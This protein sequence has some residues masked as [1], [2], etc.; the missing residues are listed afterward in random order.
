MR[1]II[2]CGI[3]IT[4]LLILIIPNT[5]QQF[6]SSHNYSPKNCDECHGV[7][8][9]NGIMDN[10]SCQTCHAQSHVSSPS[11]INCHSNTT[12]SSANEAHSPLITHA[13]SSSL[14]RDD[15]EACY[16]CHNNL[17]IDYCYDRPEY[18][19]F[20]ITNNSGNWDINNLNEG[21]IVSDTIVIEKENKSH[22]WTSGGI[23][24]ECHMDVSKNVSLHYPSSTSHSNCN[25]C[26]G[27]SASEH[28]ATV[29]ECSDPGCHVNHVGNLIAEIGNQPEEYRGNMCLGC[30][31]EGHSVVNVANTTTMGFKVYLEVI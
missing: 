9:Y 12:I 31:G 21:P 15:N 14:L 2:T 29:V 5:I 25:D 4:A 10:A 6:E 23:C 3:G 7:Y 11:C 19:E 27:K 17:Y 30:H 16:F 20:E 18:I 13:Q 1:T 8:L 24:V 28:V 26:H 22:K